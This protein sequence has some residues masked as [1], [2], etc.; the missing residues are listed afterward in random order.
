MSVPAAYAGLIIIW[1]TTP[2]AIKWSSAGPGFLFG[3]M[4]RMVL[5]VFLCLLLL[6]ILK[7]RLPMQPNARRVYLFGGLSLYS[8]ML[9]IYW[10]IQYI[11]SGLVSV[12]FGLSPILT[13][14]LAS[15]WLQ[16]SGLTITKVIGIALGI[17]GLA[18][19]FQSGLHVS[20]QSIYGII[21]VLFAV[22][23]HSVS[24]VWI[25]SVGQGMSAAA[26]TT[27]ELLVAVPLFVITWWVFDG[28]MPKEMPVRAGLAILYLG[29]IG[30]VLG[31]M[32]YFYIL[33]KMQVATVTLIMLVTPVMALF[34]GHWIDHE[35]IHNIVWM[36]TGLILSGM[37]LHQAPDKFLARK[38]LK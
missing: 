33:K 30:S 9:T 4:G 5:G 6:K 34:L 35:P 15:W 3:V 23:V 17:S 22:C 19:V 18:L 10:S 27:G 8:A 20:Q 24:S 16:E 14:V 11:P 21:G 32:L 37:L 26:I 1:S 36:G 25:K 31:F 13:S 12:I 38:M 28:N 7:I 2:L 29:T